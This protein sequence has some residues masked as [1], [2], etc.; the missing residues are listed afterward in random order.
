MEN[1]T[2]TDH[3]KRL[4]FPSSLNT[5]FTPSIDTSPAKFRNLVEKTSSPSELLLPLFSG[6]SIACDHNHLIISRPKARLKAAN[7]DLSA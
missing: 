4:N 7:V 5:C 2:I 3:T 6:S 1:N